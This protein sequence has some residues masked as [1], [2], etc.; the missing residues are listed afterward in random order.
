MWFQHW[1]ADRNVPGVIG[2]DVRVTLLLSRS[3]FSGECSG[4]V[5][6]WKYIVFQACKRSKKSCSL[7]PVGGVFLL[8][9]RYHVTEQSSSTAI[10]LINYF[11]TT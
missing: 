7:A 3:T 10:R 6:K 11:L 9:L 1:R 4:L 2:L 8:A 5:I